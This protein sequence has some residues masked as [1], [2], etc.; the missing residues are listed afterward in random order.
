MATA[1]LPDGGYAGVVS[2]TV[3]FVVDA[4]VV[5]VFA[6][7]T[8][9]VVQL[10]VSVIG[11]ERRDLARAAVPVFLAAVPAML[12]S[13]NFLFWALTGRTPGMALLG[14]RVTSTAGRRVRWI[15]AL[16]RA[17]VLAYFPIGSVWCVV[18]RRRQA[19]HDKLAG[20]VV[21][22]TSPVPAS[23]VR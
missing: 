18:D 19:V 12:A 6:V 16:V 4:A 22:R 20:T 21:I 7:G 8:V 14:L 9:A 23:P 3:A 5:G 13:Y 11:A 1:T 15:P 2:R 10:V 17:V